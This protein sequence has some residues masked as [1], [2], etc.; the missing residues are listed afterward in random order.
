MEGVKEKNQKPKKCEGL[1]VVTVKKALGVNGTRI[2]GLLRVVRNSSTI[3]LK[4]L[5]VKR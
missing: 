1:S 5:D 2:E 3:S 4:G